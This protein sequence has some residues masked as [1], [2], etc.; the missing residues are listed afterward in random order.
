MPARSARK[1]SAIAALRILSKAQAAEVVA[2]RRADPPD[3]RSGP[4]TP[5]AEDR[6]APSADE[7]GE[8]A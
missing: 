5:V 3:R 1:P 6:A 7:S 8:R 4:Q 2:A